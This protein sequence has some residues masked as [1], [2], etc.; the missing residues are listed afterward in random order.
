MPNLTI[1]LRKYLSVYGVDDTIAVR[2]HEWR[3]AKPRVLIAK[4][5]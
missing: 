1:A 4:Q 3:E 5:Q 2:H